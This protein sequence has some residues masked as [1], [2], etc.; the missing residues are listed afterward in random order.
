MAKKI[1]GQVTIWVVVAVILVSSIILFFFI[2]RGPEPG[3]VS[4]GVSGFDAQTF[5][6]NCIIPEVERN[7]NLM[8]PQGGFIQPESSVFFDNLEIEYLCK[9]DGF[10]EPCI[11][12]HPRLLSEM[13]EEIHISVL[14][15]IVSCFDEMEEV[16][17]DRG[18]EVV[19]DGAVELEVDSASDVIYLNIK[20][21]TSIGK[22]GE[23]RRFDNFVIE[24]K[25]P[26]HNLG[27][28][29]IEIADQE[30]RYCNFEYV[31][32]GILYPRYRISKS[33]SSNQD[34]IYNIE[35]LK[36]GKEMNIAIRGCAIPAG[37]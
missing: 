30:A 25:N 9:N 15:K 18:S 14:P 17:E 8:L 21:K 27:S 3:R 7:V 4:G 26:M 36:S 31:G 1:K 32:Y 19:Y 33:V 16:F 5:L 37:F 35:D 28:I 11:Q 29:A 13:E 22:E 20:R 12:Q 24:I 6:S 2:E 34:K 23:V 10:Y